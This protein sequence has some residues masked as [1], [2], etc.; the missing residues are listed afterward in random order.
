MRFMNRF[1]VL[2]D[3]HG[4]YEAL[5]KALR[6][7]KK[8][9]VG[10]IVFLG[11]AIGYG[12]DPLKCYKI[13]KEASDIYLMGN[14]EAML[15]DQEQKMSELCRT[16]LKWTKNEL[17]VLQESEIA[18]LKTE[19]YV[20]DYGFFHSAPGAT[21][22]EWKY[23]NDKNE[24]INAFEDAPGVCFYG[25]TH[26]PRITITGFEEKDEYIKSTQEFIIDL[27]K[28]R[29]YIN[30]GSVGQQRDDRTD[31]SFAICEREGNLLKIRIERHCYNSFKAYLKIRFK[32][33]GKEVAD[34]LIRERRKK[35]IYE[36]IGDRL[37]W[38][39]R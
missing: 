7:I 4:N 11:D 16:S 23:L 22:T 15:I 32:G 8:R 6:I 33:C 3:V 36:S 39:Y 26:R 29:V 18:E 19:C 17:Y 31:L 9:G 27:G 34:Y 20:K 14:H 2:A 10:Q 35:R 30:P 5:S 21:I 24:I 38:L 28:Q 12:A 1:A 13:V 37:G 25:H